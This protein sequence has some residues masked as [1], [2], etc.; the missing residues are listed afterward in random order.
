MGK[1]GEI[2]QHCLSERVCIMACPKCLGQLI[3]IWHDKK[4]DG[5]FRHRPKRLAVVCRPCN[6]DLASIK[7]PEGPLME[8]IKK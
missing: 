4:A 1:T 7:Q 8:I 3:E 2:P 6:F 5:T